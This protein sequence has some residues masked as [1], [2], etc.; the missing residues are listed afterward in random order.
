MGRLKPSAPTKGD[1]LSVRDSRAG[2]WRQSR[3][4]VLALSLC[5]LTAM[6]TLDSSKF[7]LASD[8]G[9]VTAATG[10]QGSGAA[11]TLASLLVP[12][13]RPAASVPVTPN[14]QHRRPFPGAAS[15][16]PLTGT[17]PPI[18]P[19][20]AQAPGAPTITY[21]APASVPAGGGALVT[22]TGTGF[23][24]ASA[25]YFGPN[26]SSQFAVV[27]PT[28]ITAVAPTDQGSVGVTVTT[29]LGSSVQTQGSQL[30]YT[31]TGQPPITAS[32]QNLEIAG[33]P[34][35][36][37]GVNAYEL[38]TDW[39]TNHGCG[40]META[41]QTAALFASLPPHSIVRF[42]AFQGDLATDATTHEIDWTPI[43][44]V[45]YLAAA[46]HVY[47]I[48]SITDQGGTC[49][50]GHWQDPSWY[51]GG[52]REVFDTATDADGTGDTPLSYWDYLQELV[53]RYENSPA[54]G[55]WEPIS[56]AEAS[57]CAAAYQP[58][59]CSGHQ[60]CPDEA[61][62][63]ADLTSFF[64]TVGGEIRSLDPTHLIEEGLLGGSQCG[65]VGSDYQAVG[66]SPGIDVLSVH[67]YYGP[68]PLGGDP[69]NG[70]A[71]RFSQAAALNK[72]IIT[73]EVGIMAGSAPG[74][75]SFAQR[76][77]D[78]QAK[79]QA[80]FAAGSSAFLVW[81]WVLDP[82]GPCSYNTGPGDPL[83]ATLATAG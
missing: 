68:A 30:A 16:A 80:Q 12:H 37:V 47:L 78:L 74:C 41:A 77:S 13:G 50:G 65:M 27:S 55:M 73:G 4:G 76:A 24:A 70:L 82:L 3:L 52:Y 60:T 26:E 9:A 18:S 39:G 53:D 54:L 22:I 1:D 62:A 10:T 66:A 32:G 40:G 59:D 6:L 67:D 42:W 5:V 35:K 51:T 57:S 19:A 64:T 58:L 25:V 63:A 29:P 83:L 75:E 21:L 17:V 61:A 56:E 81:N 20:I 49:D 45:F 8:G 72:P 71:A 23:D 69:S 43:D 28:I 38:A 11:G 14:G 46:Y 7:A 36:F 33:T 44:Q 2:R 15:S 79:A 31:S 48:P 34:T